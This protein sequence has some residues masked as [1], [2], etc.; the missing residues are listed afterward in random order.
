[1]RGADG[2]R[3]RRRRFC[4]LES[5]SKNPAIKKI[6]TTTVANLRTECFGINKLLAALRDAT[7]SKLDASELPRRRSQFVPRVIYPG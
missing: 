4:A 2:A 6:A 5:S 7:Y 3:L 1:M